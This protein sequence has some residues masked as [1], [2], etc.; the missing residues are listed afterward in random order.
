MSRLENEDN[1]M[2]LM[3]V[4]SDVAERIRTDQQ[5]NKSPCIVNM[6]VEL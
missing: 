4:W 6:V 5:R 3:Q 1:E 2:D